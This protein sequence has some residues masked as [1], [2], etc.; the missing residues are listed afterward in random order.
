MIT[1]SFLNAVKRASAL[2]M[3]FV[4]VLAGGAFAQDEE[5]TEEE[6]AKYVAVEDSTAAYAAVRSQEYSQM[7]KDHELMDGG[8]RY[9]ALKGA[10]GNEEKLA[11][12]EAT[13]EEIAAYQYI[14]D[15][16]AKLQ[17]EVKE[18]KISLIKDDEFCGIATFNK[19][20]AAVRADQE[21]NAKFKEMMAEKKEEREGAAEDTEE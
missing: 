18:L 8:R 19:V 7:I 13:E 17:E 6:L 2:S 10:W 5:V 14:L 16:Y 20:N 12:I 21:L 15:E 1:K 3:L 11:K 4:A 9:V